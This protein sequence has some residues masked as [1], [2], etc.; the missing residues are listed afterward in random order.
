MEGAHL[1]LSALQTERKRVDISTKE[2]IPADIPPQGA[3][4]KWGHGATGL[5]VSSAWDGLGGPVGKVRQM[6]EGPPS[7]FLPL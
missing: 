2:I 3:V 4:T 5:E 1:H 6:A 7:S